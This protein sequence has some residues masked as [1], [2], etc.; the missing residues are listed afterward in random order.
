MSEGE[1]R[2]IALATFLS[3]L[4]ISEHQSS[5]IFDDPVSSLDHKWRN[6]IAKR[7][8]IESKIRQVIVFTHDITFLLMLQEHCAKLQLRHRQ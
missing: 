4:S 5:I 1:H 8:A 7:I 6:R 3:E 2:C